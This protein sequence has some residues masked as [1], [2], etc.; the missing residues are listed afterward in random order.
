MAKAPLPPVPDGLIALLAADDAL[1]STEEAFAATELAAE[2]AALICDESA[3]LKEERED[4]AAEEAEDAAE[5]AALF[6]LNI[7]KGIDIRLLEKTY[8]E[9]EEAAPL[10]VD[11]ATGLVEVCAYAAS[12]KKERVTMESLIVSFCFTFWGYVSENKEAGIWGSDWKP[13]AL[14]AF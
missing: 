10:G 1:D 9:A 3:E 11:E 4:E 13:F 7:R 12:A 5:D 6:V 8:L 14:Y 2:L